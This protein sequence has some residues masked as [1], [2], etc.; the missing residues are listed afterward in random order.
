MGVSYEWSGVL[1]GRGNPVRGTVS[2]SGYLKL[3]VTDLLARSDQDSIHIAVEDDA[4]GCPDD[5]DDGD[6]GCD[7]DPGDPFEPP[8]PC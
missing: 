2:E 3:T 5:D 6:D 1:T 8:E 7:G 4:G